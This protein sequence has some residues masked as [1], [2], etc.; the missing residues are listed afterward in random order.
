MAKKVTDGKVEV[1]F[2]YSGQRYRALIPCAALVSLIT[3]AAPGE[4][5]ANLGSEGVMPFD[6]FVDAFYMP[7]HAKSNKKPSAY[8]SDCCSVVTLKKFFGSKPLHLIA[9]GMREDFKQQRLAGILSASGKPCANNTVNRELSC[10]NQVMEYAVGMDYLKEN[11]LAGLKRL[12]IVHRAMFWLSKKQF[13][14]QIVPASMEY[15]GGRYRDLVEFATCSGARLNEAL[16]AH[17]DDI[18]W[19]RSELRLLTL[20]RRK[21]MKVYRYISI[22]EIGPRL[23]NVL[24]R[25]KPHPETGY[26]F[27]KK[28]GQPRDSGHMDHVFGDICERAKL[29]QFHFHD[30]RHTFA[31]HRAM[32]QITFRQLQIELGHSSPQSVQAYLDEAARFEPEQSLFCRD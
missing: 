21:R 11:P 32:T 22:K 15:K 28:N 20:K 14:E 17:K 24:K 16:V 13:D 6:H 2:T 18:N 7:R 25:L 31:M 27:T 5:N 4:A 12:P 1:D 8:E 19:D 30:L 23:D 26:F 29:A 10:L 9:K 3:G